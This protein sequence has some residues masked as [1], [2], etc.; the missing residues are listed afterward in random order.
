[1]HS[2][3]KGPCGEAPLVCGSQNTVW[4]VLSPPLTDVAL[5]I[6]SPI[7]SQSSFCF[8]FFSV[9]PICGAMNNMLLKSVSP[10][11]GHMILLP[12]N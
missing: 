6:G 12:Q 4:P 3:M 1:M 8:V 7:M 11:P 5:G 10:R 2:H 9:T